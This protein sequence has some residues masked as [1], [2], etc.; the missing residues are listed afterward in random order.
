MRKGKITI[1]IP[2]Y[3]DERS[4]I[5]ENARLLDEFYEKCENRPDE[6]VEANVQSFFDAY[7]KLEQ[8]QKELASSEWAHAREISSIIGDMLNKA[9]HRFD[10][11]GI[12]IKCNYDS[13]DVEVLR[14]FDRIREVF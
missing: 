7:N 4:V 11:L 6:V 5:Q 12:I 2:R 14:T 10:E 9:K 1:S 8:M 13:D 3:N